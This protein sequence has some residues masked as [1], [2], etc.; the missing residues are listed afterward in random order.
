MNNR[1]IYLGICLLCLLVSLAVVTP[2]RIARADDK[3]KPA[4][5]VAKHLESIG[6]AEARSTLHAAQVKGTCSIIVT[7]GGSG[8][9]DGQ[10]VMVSQGNQNMI[11]MTFDSGDYPSEELKFDGK[12]YFG[13]QIHPG[14][15]SAIGSFFNTNDI[16][17]KEGLVGS[18]LSSSWP[19]L[20]V[21]EKN[22]RLE[23]AGTKNI[24][25]RD[26]VGLK[27]VPRKGSD[28]KITLYFD[29]QNFHHV[30]TEYQATVYAT[31]QVKIAGGGGALPSAHDQRS[32]NAR[33][34]AYE[35]FSDF[36]TEGA[37]T[38]P[39]SYNFHLA[40]Q[41]EVHPAIVDWQIKLSE[42]VINPQLDAKW[43]SS[44]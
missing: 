44:E 18:V 38:L 23:Y 29:A 25:G 1:L 31:D 19:L 35:E 42:F 8:Q 37:L 6:P 36:K 9:V 14:R 15:R 27:Y 33:I 39:H 13:S 43:F 30:R 32:S 24:G 3:P 26:L 34:E 5:I 41:S 17:F 7:Q 2:F 4:D 21:Q 12:K 16:L 11:R 28:L 20:N 40:V 10:V 22:P